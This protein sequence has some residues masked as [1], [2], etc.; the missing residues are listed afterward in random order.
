MRLPL[1][2]KRFGLPDCGP[3]AFNFVKT[4]WHFRC[5]F[6]NWSH[7]SHPCIIHYENNKWIL[8]FTSRDCFKRSHIFLASV[9]VK[10]GSICC[11]SDFVEALAPGPPCS[12]DCDGV[13][14]GCFV[15]DGGS[16]YLYYVGWQNLPDGLWICD[17]G[18]ARLDPRNLS[19]EKEY[20]G[21]I[22]GRDRHHPL[23]AAA[24]SFYRSDSG[25]W[26]TWYNSGISW[27]KLG[28]KWH[29]KYGLHHATSLNGLDWNFEP[30]MAIPFADESEYAFGRPSVIDF[31]GRLHMWFAHRGSRGVDRYRIG[32]A[33]STDAKIWLR[34]DS[35][36]GIDA[37]ESGWDSEMICYPC[38]FNCEGR[39]HMLY[40]G[41]DYGKTG[42]GLAINFDENK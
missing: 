23:F 37:S 34:N 33:S 10:D 32:Y 16:F 28:D 7:A 24:T 30:G 20:S 18:R 12:F 3:M 15:R 27:T 8:A 11:T 42:F 4:G 38:V 35:L 6:D 26:H 9:E 25:L 39:L 21:P 17:T 36:S 14:S 5:P 29:H 41:N 2:N 19:L 22:I 40:N 1:V 31:N 13:I